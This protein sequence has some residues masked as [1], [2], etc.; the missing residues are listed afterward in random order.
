MDFFNKL[1]DTLTNKGQDVTKKAMEIAEIT[2][3][4]AQIAGYENHMKQIYTQLGERYFKNNCDNPDTIYEDLLTLL[5]EDF[6][7]IA[8]CQDQIIKAKNQ[9][10]C[11][12][13]GKAMDASALYCPSCGTKNDIPEEGEVIDTDTTCPECGKEVDKADNFCPACG[14]RLHPEEEE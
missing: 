4:N 7:Q 5:R 1:G 12:G 8:R 10:V 6:R 9:K 11:K 3:L 14:A 2:K 13:C